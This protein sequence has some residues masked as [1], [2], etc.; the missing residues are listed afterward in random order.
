MAA[1]P[2]ERTLPDTDEQLA[3][4]IGRGDDVAF[5]EL[6]RRYTKPLTG[7]AGRILRD[8][9]AGE[10]VAQTALL[11]AFR[12]LRGGTVPLS[13]R[14]WLYRIAQ[15]AALTLY[16]SRHGE[17][18]EPELEET[19]ARIADTAFDR[20]AWLAGLRSLP[21]RQRLVY[22]L[23]DV[24]GVG[25]EEVSTRV[26]LTAVQV[27]QAL[28]AARN[29]LAEHLSFGGRVDCD[30]VRSVAS[31]EGDRR[32]LKAHLRACASCR[33][34]LVKAK[35]GLV[36]SLGAWA[37]QVAEWT[38]GGGGLAPL[39]AKVGAIVATTALGAAA[40][41]AA[42]HA[43]EHAVSPNKPALQ[44]PAFDGALVPP[45]TEPAAMD[46][47]GSGGV[48][49]TSLAALI[50]GPD[51]TGQGHAATGSDFIAV[52]P[53]DPS[54]GSSGTGDGSGNTTDETGQDVTGQSSNEQ[55]PT[56]TEAD[57]GAT[58]P[59][60]VDENPPP[61]ASASD[62]TPVDTTPVDTTP[63]DTTPVD[64]TPVDTTP[65]D[66]TPVDTTPTP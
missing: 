3:A 4:R 30:T 43:V 59:V 33:D 64:T 5:D 8:P 48:F 2:E 16:R 46:V 15:N 23:R 27:E 24:N 7:F 14:P 28:F 20:E 60:P 54:G 21:A 31:E 18:V 36:T 65:V 55:N 32:P 34:M 6:Y 61:D 57:T 35:V 44:Q 39:T 12:S 63:V 11:N 19:P 51:T 22:V 56:K 25:T 41:P 29:R 42:V 40:T 62:G 17:I 47:F 45:A 66:T 10:D 38:V 9:A 53:S 26:G 49:G 52:G 13:V 50:P 1:L 58:D 37:R